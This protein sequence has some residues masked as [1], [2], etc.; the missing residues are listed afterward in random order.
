MQSWFDGIRVQYAESSISS[1]IYSALLFN[2]SMDAHLVACKVKYVYLDDKELRV[3]TDIGISDAFNRVVV[4]SR[5]AL[6]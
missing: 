4:G 2:L 6:V 1:D 5:Q 3:L